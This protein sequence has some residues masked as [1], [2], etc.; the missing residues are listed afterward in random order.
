PLMVAVAAFIIALVLL[1]P[2]ALVDGL[3]RYSARY[4]G[5]KLSIFYD[6]DCGFC[7]KT[8]LLFRTFLLLGNTPIRPAQSDPDIGPILEKHNSWVVV[9]RDGSIALHWHAVLL[10]MRRSVIARPLGL[11]LTAVGMGHWG[12]GLYTAI[13]NSRGL[14][15]KISAAVLPL[16]NEPAPA[17]SDWRLFAL[18]WLIASLLVNANLQFAGLATAFGLVR[19][20]V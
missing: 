17:T 11:L 10:V 3:A 20:A 13:G 7:L 1:T 19:L 9:D 8:C 4:H 15:S 14:L 16:R 2:T 18:A 5:N 6:K 12:R